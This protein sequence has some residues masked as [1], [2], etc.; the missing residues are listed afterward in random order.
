M[1]K[2]ICEVCGHKNFDL[3]WFD[4]IRCSSK[5]FTKNKK[6]ILKCK[7]CNLVF[8]SKKNRV[9]EDSSIARNIYNKNNS[10]KE[11]IKFHKSREIK[12]LDFLYD[13]IE[14][15][16]KKFLESN[17]GTGIILSKIKKKSKST[18]GVD[19][20]HY[21]EFLNSMGHTHYN[22][23]DYPIKNKLTYDYI[24]SLSELEHKF[25]PK[26]FLK[27]IQKILDK[28]GKLFIRVPNFNNIYMSLLGNNFLKYDFRTSHNFYFSKENLDIL[29]KKTNFNIEKIFGFH[30]YDFNHLLEYLKTQKRVYG[31]YRMVFSKKDSN[32]VIKNIEANLI[33]TSLIYILSKK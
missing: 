25:N 2:A 26:N 5:K 22:N 6:K 17:C 18:T 3:I 28:K 33:S 32:K 20:M 12:K 15:K 8:L 19:S 21:K 13:Y 31:D 4:K 23:L 30:E 24:F 27:D 11:F 16:N 14:P 10:M 7:K 1:K 9:L 29:F